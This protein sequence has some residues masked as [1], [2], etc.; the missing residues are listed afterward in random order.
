M[1]GH[2]P[3]PDPTGPATSK[4]SFP[5]AVAAGIM[6]V[7]TLALWG[8]HMRNSQQK[9]GGPDDAPGRTSRRRRFNDMAVVGSSVTI[10]RPR[11]ELYAFWRDFSNLPVFMENIHSVE[12]L[13]DLTTWTIRAP[14]GSNVQVKTCI[15]ADK[16]DA[17]IAWRSVEGSDI[18]T[19]GKV[20]F[21]D[22]P[23]GRGTIVEA[24]VAYRPPAGEVGRLIAKLFQDEPRI[25]TRRDLKRF[26][27]LM[28]TGEI[29]TAQNR[30]SE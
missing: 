8:I 5:L 10:N 30:N 9:Y 13:D 18:K 16:P 6:T 11:S 7:G 29:S 12:T 24:I 3:R 17:Q 26:K 1:S 22:A 4:V 20:M 15:V 28:E 14:A 19:K 2:P 21:R 25:Q 27:M 23:G